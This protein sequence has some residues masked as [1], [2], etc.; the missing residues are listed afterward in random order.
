MTI[1]GFLSKMV[2]W[3]LLPNITKLLDRYMPREQSVLAPGRWS[4]AW[5]GERGERVCVEAP[6]GKELAEARA[7]EK[8]QLMQNAGRKRARRAS[9]AQCASQETSASVWEEVDEEEAAADQQR[10]V[11]LWNSNRVKNAIQTAPLQHMGV[12]LNIMG[13]FGLLIQS[14]VRLGKEPAL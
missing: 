13:S 6:C 5:Q 1:R 2:R 7:E 8:A 10:N 11:E 12:K 9:R 4:S 3:Y 14:F